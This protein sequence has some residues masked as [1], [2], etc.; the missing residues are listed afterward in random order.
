MPT[1]NTAQKMVSGWT[2]LDTD[3]F[4]PETLAVATEQTMRMKARYAAPH[5][6]FGGTPKRA[7]KGRAAPSVLVNLK[8]GVP[9]LKLRKLFKGH[10]A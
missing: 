5:A 1:L 9:M 10:R 6:R 7:R 8:T 2:G 4:T 3:F